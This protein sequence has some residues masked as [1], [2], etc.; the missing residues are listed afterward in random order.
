MTNR[1]KFAEQILDIACSNDAIAVDKATLEPIACGKSDC[2]DCLFNV[3]DVMSCG[4]KRINWS[5]SEYVEPPVDW[6]KVAVDTPI[7]VNDSNDHRWLKRY[8]AKYENGSVYAWDGGRTSWSD[9]EHAAAWD[10]AKLPDK[11]AGMERLTIDEIIEHC[12][13]KTE[14]YEKACDVKYLE[15]AVMGNRIKEYWEHKQVA[16]YLRKLKYYEDL[17][18]QG[19]FV[20][21]P[22]KYVYNIVDI[23][24]PKYAMVMKR[25]IRELAIYEIEDIDKENCKYFSTEEKAEA[26]LKELRGGENG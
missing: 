13:R 8:F 22:C 3:S 11:E 21:L 14:M 15:T 7:L 1:E 19:R 2:K 4:D 6:S 23:N 26:K 12:N 20:K 5:N 10:L 17:E 9:G 18:E 24:N 25:T 16:K